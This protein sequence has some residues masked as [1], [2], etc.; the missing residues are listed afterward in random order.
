MTMK[1]ATNKINSGMKIDQP[2]YVYLCKTEDSYQIFNIVAHN[3]MEV[4][5]FYGAHFPDRELTSISRNLKVQNAL[6]ES[7]IRDT[8]MD[9]NEDGGNPPTDGVLSLL[10]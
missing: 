7:I 4:L 3:I 9:T 1:T 8:D 10:Q 2:M 6:T 5:N